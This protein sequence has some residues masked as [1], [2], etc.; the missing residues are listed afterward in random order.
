MPLY[1]KKRIVITGLGVLA[2]NGIGKDAF[3]GA[4]KDG[5]SG[6]KPV[7]LFETGTTKSRLAGEISGFQPETILGTK[8]LRTLDRSTKLA[9]CASQLALD[10]AGIK[11]PLSES[12]TDTFGVSLGSTMGS[13]WSISEFDKESLRNG[14]R[15]VNPA[16]FANTVINS[17]ASHISIRFNIQGFNA[18]I[19]TG[20]CSSPDAVYYAMNM[21]NLYDYDTVLAGGVEELCEQTYKGF[22]K[23]GLLAGSRDG[24]E[25]ISCPFDKRRNGIVLGEGAAVVV[26]EELGHA[27]KR[28]A[29]IYAEMLGYGTAFD[30]E[31]SNICSPMARGAVKSISACL[32]DAGV[33]IDDIGYVSA[34]ANSTLDCDYME[35]K[36]LKA[37]FGERSGEL[38]L[39]SIKSMGG[40]CFSA[41]GA[42]NAAAGVGVLTRG[43]LPPTINYSE[44]DRRCDMNCI[45]NKS[46]EAGVEKVLVNTFSPTGSNSSLV[47]GKFSK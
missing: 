22:H 10:D 8:G 33:G 32:R 43:F 38:A 7:T 2:S 30:P 45:P 6:I 12:E 39:S 14:P 42:L 36:A 23:I 25:E 19:S 11:Y 41:S 27:L 5:K 24:K 1:G 18:T 13:V 35:T 44:K 21:I 9:L 47:I 46:V 31:S 34:S 20:F 40:E 17:P 26:L 3:W 16:L 37:V 28:N 15:S 29:R 4:L